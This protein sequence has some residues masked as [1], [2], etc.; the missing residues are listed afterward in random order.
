MPGKGKGLVAVEDIPRGT[1]ILE[2]TP[3]IA[4][5]DSPLK[6]N[7]LKAQI[8]QQMNFLND[9][10]EIRRKRLQDKFGF[11]CSCKLCSL[12]EE[13]SEQ[14]DKR[15]A[16]IDQLDEL[17]GRDGMAMN[18]SLR[19]FR[20]AEERI[21]L[22]EEQISGD[23]GLSRTYMDAAKVAI[24]K[25]DLARG[26]IFAERAVDGWRAGGGNDRKEVLEYGDLCKNPAKLSL[27][28]LSMEWKTSVDE[29]PQG[30]NQ[31][32]F[33]DWLWR[34]WTKAYGEKMQ[35]ST[36]FRDRAAFPSFAGLPNKGGFYGVHE[37]SVNID[38]PLKHW[39]F[40]GEITN[41][42]SLAHL[43]LELV[44]SDDKKLPL[45]FYT[46]QRGQEVDV[47]QLRVGYTVAI[48][49]A[50]RYRF[51]YGN[52]GIRHE[53]PQMLKIF[54]TPLKTLL[55]LSDRECQKIGWNE[56]RHKADCKM[57]K[58]LDLRGLL[59]FEWTEADTRASFP[60]TAV[61]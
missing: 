18:L 51:V 13:Q 16:R 61:V 58:H 47:A 11:L 60:L 30:L 23:A 6:D 24:A 20:Y 21:R 32:D 27:D 26:R 40:L 53:N 49:Y 19:T 31:S 8:V 33:D 36:G 46:E 55:E 1:R 3:I 28:G 50:Q 12:P 54:P 25:G 56:R 34:R 48:L 38:Q 17:I 22:Y 52:P 2:E 29:V 45:H 59:G 44:D 9:A 35:C 5:P 42:S 57:L 41:F 7:L 14:S 43:E 10:R 4:I 37:E 39:C 15:L